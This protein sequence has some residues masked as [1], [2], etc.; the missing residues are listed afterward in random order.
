MKKK[1]TYLWEIL[2]MLTFL[3]A[4]N[5]IWKRNDPGFIHVNP[6]PYWLVILPIAVKYELKEALAASFF[7]SIVYLVFVRIAIPDLPWAQLFQFTLFKPVLLFVFIGGLI[8]QIQA[9][10]HAKLQKE[11]AEK[12]EL[13]QKFTRFK[14]EYED[15]KHWNKELSERVAKQS[16]TVSTL[17]KMARKLNVF[18]KKKLFH[19]SLE[20]VQ[21]IIGAEKCSIYAVEKDQLVLQTQLGWQSGDESRYLKNVTSD[22]VRQAMTNRKVV[23]LNMLSEEEF[24]NDHALIMAA[25]ITCGPEQRICGIINIE[26]MPFLKF[27]LESIRQLEVIAD[28]VSHS[29]TL[30]Q[31]IKKVG[32]APKT[33]AQFDQYVKANFKGVFQ[34]GTPVS[35]LYN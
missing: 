25:P 6:H 12:Q 28:W 30:S 7:S 11:L 14:A 8:G 3:T 9:A 5:F 1:Y 4:I 29:L 27:N 31:E 2:G 17:Y 15:L 13:E 20:L 32:A 10:Q 34:F 24:E 23:A 35:Q 18:E 21:T 22:V 26:A 19:A 33:S 16:Y